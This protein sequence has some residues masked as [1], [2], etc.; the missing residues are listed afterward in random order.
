M[1]YTMNINMTTEELIQNIAEAIKD[2]GIDEYWTID[3]IA[4]FITSQ[5]G[6]ITGF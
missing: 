5:K 2:A 1:E 3:E 4:F 6:R